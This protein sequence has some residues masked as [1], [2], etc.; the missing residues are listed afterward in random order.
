M[1]LKQ[2]NDWA[3]AVGETFSA[4]GGK[5]LRKLLA[6]LDRSL[7][8]GRWEAGV[9]GAR[10]FSAAALRWH[11]PELPAAAAAVLGLSAPAGAPPEGFPRL[12]FIWDFEAGQIFDARVYGAGGG[13]RRCR[14]R[15]AGEERLL[16]AAPFK[17]KAFGEPVARALADFSALAPV[18]QAV[19]E[20]GTAR[21]ALRL[22]EG[23]C[24]PDFLRLEIAAVFSSGGG[25][26]A[27]L[28]RDLRVRELS[29]DGEALW[30]FA[31]A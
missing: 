21:W 14:Y 18:A 12:S 7:P 25:Q 29:F 22:S 23:L 5:G 6:D 2:R 30:A 3:A 11:G 26:S 20:P 17:A 31:G 10:G 4:D 13:P 28:M 19:V 15:A 1:N 9:S 24:W 8:P 27:L 16:E